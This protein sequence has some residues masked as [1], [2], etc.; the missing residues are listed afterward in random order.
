MQSIKLSD[1]RIGPRLRTNPQDFEDLSDLDSIETRGLVQPI[2]LELVQDA[3]LH[4]T[5]QLVAGHR[6]LCKL[7][8]LGQEELFHGNTCIPNKPGFVW[9][10]ELE[11]DVRQE[12]E[13]YENL[14]RTQM[15]WKDRVVAITTIHQLKKR[16]AALDS[17]H[18]GQA[19][20]GRELGVEASYV[21]YAV[22]VADEL[23]NAE[24]KIHDCKG[25]TDAIRFL[26]ERRADLASK[27]LAELTIK[28]LPVALNNSTAPQPTKLGDGQDA[29]LTVPLSRICQH[30][31][32]VALCAK[33]GPNSV[34]HIITDWPYAIDMDYLEQGQGMNVD[35]VRA[36]HDVKDNLSN[37]PVWLDSMF[38]V[39]KP[40]GFCV[41]WYDNVNWELIRQTAETVGFRVQRW[42]LVWIKTSPCLN[43]MASKNWTKATEFAVVLSKQNATL[44]KP[45]ATNYWSGPR[46]STTSNPFAKPKALWQWILSAFALRGDT[47]LDPFAGEGST[48]LATIDFGC[49]PIAFESNENH[50]AQL[51]N[52]VHEFY[53]QLT[54]GNVQ[55]T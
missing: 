52:N 46:A 11:P 8:E 35:R 18:W 49:S 15:G 21:S 28:T 31:D 42:P 40:K 51:V 54:K 22:A 38:T 30:G 3:E 14:G 27:Q 33:L 12:L 34:D 55:F 44:I 6:R 1:I 39:L 4:C 26:A 17:E 13:L 32:M 20:T 50:F 47:I 43:Q 10:S 5:P 23:K 25:F 9:V 37:Y 16:R 41:V 7:R 45:Q 48:T 19:E 53:K 24:S 2:V 29:P 36:E